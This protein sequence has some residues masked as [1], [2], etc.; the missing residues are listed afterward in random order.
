MSAIIRNVRLVLTALE[1]E[2]GGAQIA[3][4]HLPEI[5]E[6]RRA[7]AATRGMDVIVAVDN[8]LRSG[9]SP[10]IDLRE[11]TRID[12][13]DTGERAPQGRMSLRFR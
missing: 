10:R 12:P 4:L 1:A 8:L 13:K 7:L 3:E 11:Q 6:A 5:A 2:R 9:L